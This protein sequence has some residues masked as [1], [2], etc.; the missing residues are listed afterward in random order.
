M[1][2][3]AE[4]VLTER[5]KEARRLASDARTRLHEQHGAAARDGVARVGAGLL[6]PGLGRVVTGFHAFGNEIDVAPLLSALAAAG[7]VTALP[8]ILGRGQPLAFR[9]WRPGEETVPGPYGIPMPVPTA[10]TVEPDALLVPMLAFDPQGYRLGY[11]GGFYDRTLAGLRARRHVV[12]VG[13]AFAGQQVDAVPHGMNDQPIDWILT[14]AG[15]VYPR[16]MVGKA[17]EAG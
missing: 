7:W 9:R 1:R 11:G 3:D 6:G 17:R 12:A 10:E 5:K 2:T 4:I 13:V 8:V 16:Q 14:E 15:P